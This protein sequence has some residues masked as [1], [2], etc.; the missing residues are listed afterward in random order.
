MNLGNND[1][2]RKEK[3]LMDA[4]KDGNYDDIESRITPRAFKY[5]ESNALLMGMKVGTVYIVRLVQESLLSE[6]ES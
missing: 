5:C 4:I 1:P 2:R 6:E 3:S